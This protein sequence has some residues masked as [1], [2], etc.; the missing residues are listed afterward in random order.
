[1]PAGE[2]SAGAGVNHGRALIHRSK[3]DISKCNNTMHSPHP[4]P[5]A[6]VAGGGRRGCGSGG[7]L[8]PFAKLP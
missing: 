3:I 2:W 5:G 6:P 8:A 4:A 7:A 1:M